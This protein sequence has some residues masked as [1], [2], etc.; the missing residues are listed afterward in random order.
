MTFG[1]GLSRVLVALI[2]IA[3]MLVFEGVLPFLMMLFWEF[4][5]RR[6]SSEGALEGGDSLD[7]L[8]DSIPSEDDQSED[9]K[10][11]LGAR[12][13]PGS[14]YFKVLY[15]AAAK[16][17]LMAMDRL[18]EHAL[19]MNGLTE[20]FYWKL[21]ILLRGGCPSSCTEDDVRQ[22]W[23]DAG[24]PRQRP[25]EGLGCF[26]WEQSRFATAVLNLDSEIDPAESYRIINM[27]ARDGNKDAI[28]Y[29][30]RGS[31]HL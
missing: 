9:S 11:N 20:A 14:R 25:A 15:E 28:L 18:A 21:K 24:C 27:M 29:L 2:P 8:D 13:R 1:S 6:D 7:D 22:T 31:H 17:N 5:C 16:G 26:T 19:R 30:E 23:L 4:S 10:K 3:A 12:W